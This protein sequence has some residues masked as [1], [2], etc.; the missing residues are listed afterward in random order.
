MEMPD[1]PAMILGP[2]GFAVMRGKMPHQFACG[3]KIACLILVLFD[4]KYDIAWGRG[5]K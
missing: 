3:G 4:G 1:S 5:G 2:G